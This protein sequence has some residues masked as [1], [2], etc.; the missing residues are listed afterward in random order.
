KALNE[1][2]DWLPKLMER[3][4]EEDLLILTADHGNDPVHHGTDHTREY[5]PLLVYNPAFQSAGSLGVRHTFADIAA[6]IDD[7]FNLTAVKNGTS[8]LND[9]Q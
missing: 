7:N 4:G 9:L 8:F 3:I 1:F 5:V 2:D 6:T